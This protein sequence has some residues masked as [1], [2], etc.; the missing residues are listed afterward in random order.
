[1]AWIYLAESE[2]SVWPCHPGS[3]QSPTVR[4]TDML[5]LFYC[6]GCGAVNFLPPQYGTTSP[7]SYL[8][9]CPDRK[10]ISS[11]ADSRA[12]TSVL[13]ELEQAWREADRSYFSRSSAWLARFDRT[14]FSWKTSQLSLFE[15]CSEFSWSSLRWGTIADGRLYQP[16]RWAPATCERDGGWVPTPT[17][18]D[19]KSP[20]V[21]RSRR[22]NRERRQGIPLSVWFKETFG[23][24]L[25]P[26]F[27]EEMMGYPSKHTG[28]EPWAIAWFRSQQG[29][30]SQ[31]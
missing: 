15:G 2:D 20:G 30:R 10:L 27:V 23:V 6:L 18:R 5:K 26:S 25:F 8:S 19:Y 22:V 24:S 12:R 31:D 17:A 11:T 14:S 9:C 21:S 13:R 7:R 3:D 28:L 16:E 29:K 4:T 1:M